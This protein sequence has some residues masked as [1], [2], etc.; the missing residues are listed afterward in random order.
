MKQ[1]QNEASGE[2]VHIDNFNVMLCSKVLFN[3]NE[4]E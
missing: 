1:V 2:G 4:S 3:F